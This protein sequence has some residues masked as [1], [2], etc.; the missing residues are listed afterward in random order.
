M[1]SNLYSIRLKKVGVTKDGEPKK[2]WL[3]YYKAPGKQK[4]TKVKAAGEWDTWS[5]AEA[6][7][8]NEERNGLQRGLKAG[9]E[10][11]HGICREWGQRD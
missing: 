8:L 11:R 5:G 9:L 4:Y 6:W 1:L 2:K 7:A 3:L 10:V